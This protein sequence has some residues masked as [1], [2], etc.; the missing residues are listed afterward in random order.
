M[1][2]ACQIKKNPTPQ[3]EEKTPQAFS[4]NSD[5]HL[6]H[7]LKSMVHIIMKCVFWLCHIDTNTQNG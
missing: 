2:N 6:T 1:I 3:K 4:R 7:F 5:S